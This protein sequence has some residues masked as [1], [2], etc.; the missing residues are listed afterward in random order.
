MTVKVNDLQKG[1]RVRLRNGWEADLLDKPKGENIRKARV[2]GAFTE[3]GSIYV[4]TI[5]EAFMNGEWVEVVLDADQR[6]FSEMK[7]QFGL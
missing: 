2:Y 3:T 1:S 4:D 7:K 5:A 6:A